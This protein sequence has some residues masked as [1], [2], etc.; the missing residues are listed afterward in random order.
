MITDPNEQKLIDQLRGEAGSVK[1]CFTNFSFTALALSG[2]ILGL[3]FGAMGRVNEVIVLAPVPIILLLMIICRIG[4]FKYSSANRHNGYELHLGRI[5]QLKLNNSQKKKNPKRDIREIRWEEA[6]RAWRIVQTNVFKSIY[7]T[8]DSTIIANIPVLNWVNH[9][10]PFLYKLTKKSKKLIDGYLCKIKYSEKEERWFEKCNEYPWFMV[11]VLTLN[12]KNSN[13]LTS[14]Y[15]AGTYLK[16]IL[17]ILLLMQYL[18]LSPIV[19]LI[20]QKYSENHRFPM[21]WSIALAVFFILILLRHIRINRR[22]EILENE[23]LSI[24]SCSIMWHAVVIAHY[25]AL[26]KTNGN[27]EHYSEY[28]TEI[29]LDLAS[30]KNVFS[31]HKWIKKNEAII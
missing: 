29:A 14:S 19:L 13:K 28:L 23:L 7:K 10:W 3:T 15:H 12:K 27:Y 2:T 22:R 4:I 16:N 8:P 18:L 25:L 9:L 17:G 31:I 11:N 5:A 20:V 21:G 30:P 26:D 24:H 1:S 6:F